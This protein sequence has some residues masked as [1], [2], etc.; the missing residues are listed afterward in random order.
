ME[1]QYRNELGRVRLNGADKRALIQRLSAR[2]APAPRPRRTLRTAAVAAAIVCV[3]V[4]AVGAV[5]ANAPVLQAYFGGGAGYDQSA[6]LVGESVTKNG[7]TMTL[8]DCVGDD[9]NLYVGFTL[10]APEGTVLDWADGYQF[11]QWSPPNFPGLKLAGSGSYEQVEDQDPSDNVVRFVLRSSYPMGGGESPNARQMELSFGGLCHNAGWNGTEYS[12]EKVYDCRE[13]WTFKAAVSYPDNVIRLESGVSVTTLGVEAAITRVEVSPLG[14][15]VYIEGDSLLGHHGWVPKNA[16]DGYYGCVEY[17]EITLYTTDG[18]AIPMTDGSVGSGCS[19]GD[20]DHP[21]S[22][23]LHL[24]R[25]S[26]AL[27]DLDSLDRIEICG[28]SIPLHAGK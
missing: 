22:A 23:Y 6:V 8:T 17:Q 25:R 28:V 19:G 12:Y 3:L 4:L 5:V 9:Y 2:G 18:A 26:G 13:S 7:W 10:T 16:P 1:E 21:E 20:L 15:Y 11:A 27:L 24:A 14:V